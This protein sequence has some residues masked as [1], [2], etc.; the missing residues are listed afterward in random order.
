MS[1]DSKE[2]IPYIFYVIM[3]LFGMLVEHYIIKNNNKREKARELDEGIMNDLKVCASQTL[4]RHTQ[5]QQSCG[6]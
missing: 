6:A 1:F 4:R 2:I 5:P 3:F